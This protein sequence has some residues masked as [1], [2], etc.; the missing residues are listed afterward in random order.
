M[1]LLRDNCAL[2]IFFHESYRCP[3][4]ALLPKAQIDA[5]EMYM[6][7]YIYIHT[8]VYRCTHIYIP[9]Y[10]GIHTLM[11]TSVYT[12]TDTH[13]EPALAIFLELGTRTHRYQTS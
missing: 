2:V 12:C 3:G 6:Y 8:C 1:L 4:I 9:V 5:F 13:I 7:M 10:T 11:Y